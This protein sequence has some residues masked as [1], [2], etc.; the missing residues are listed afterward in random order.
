MTG[1]IESIRLE[2]MKQQGFG[3]EAMKK[4]KI[5]QAC[6]N[7]SDIYQL[8][9]TNCGRRLLEKSLYEIYKE[10]HLT[11]PHCEIVITEDMDYCPQCGEEIKRLNI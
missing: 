4:I 1:S 11:C 6:G 10:R 3:T 9:C 7:T 2:N 5:C 8:F